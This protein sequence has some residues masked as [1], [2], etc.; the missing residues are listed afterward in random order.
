[1]KSIIKLIY[2]FL[3]LLAVH[4]CKQASDE[5]EEPYKAG[6]A[7]L[8]IAIN[9]VVGAIPSNGL[10]GTAVQISATG[11][12]PYKDKISFTFNGEPAEIVEIT[13][14]GIKIK[15][16]DNASSGVTAILIDDKIIFGPIFTVQGLIATDPTFVATQGA[17]GAVIQALP[18]IEGKYMLVGNFSNYDNKGVVTPNNRIVRTFLNGNIDRTLRAGTGANG[19]LLGIAQLGTQFYIA[20]AFSGYNQR[21]E[22]ISNI[23]RLNGNGTIDSM[24]IKTFR[25]PGK[26]DTIK[27]FPRFN[28]GTDGYI[29]KIYTHQGRIIVTG[30]FRYYITRRYDQPNRYQTSDSV[31]LDSTEAR[32]IIRLNPDATLDKTYR[33]DIATNKSLPA[34]NGEIGSLMHIGNGGEANDGKLLIFGS[35]TTFDNVASGYITRL[36]SDGTKDLTFNAGGV[37]ANLP[38][39]TAD[40][41]QTTG[42]YIITGEF[43]TYNGAPAVNMARLNIDGTLDNTFSPKP[44]SGGSIRGAKLLSNG[45][46]VIFGDFKKY[47]ENTRN[48]FAVLTPEGGLAPGYNATGIFNGNLFD[49]IETKSEDGKKALLL[50]G[51]FDRFD[52]TRVQNIIRVTIE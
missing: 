24:G 14:A 5:F 48:G 8:G 23:T 30:G 9:N 25:P 26:R 16:P 35:F 6:K 21:K 38:I 33:F 50:I 41:N 4:G 47:G 45:M 12:L 36:K 39:S 31:I 46:I 7:P 40:F 17:N 20:G 15:V 3:A 13:A 27:Y 19:V 32:Q 1:M 34:A 28:G 52:N 49:V 43:T 2:L 10:P 42:K 18:L 37:G 44:F 29:N 11:L 51:E 22:N